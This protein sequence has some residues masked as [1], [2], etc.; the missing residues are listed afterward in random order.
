M[1]KRDPES[2]RNSDSLIIALHARSLGTVLAITG[3]GSGAVSALLQVSGA[4]R[5]VLEAVVPYSAVAL[6]DFLGAK[7]EHFC[8]ARTARMMA[9]VAF[10]RAIQ[11]GSR[12]EPARPAGQ[13][14]G[15]G[16]TASLASDR[17]K[18]GPHRAHIAVQTAA[19]T[20]TWSLELR[21]DARSRGDEEALV[22]DL[23]LNALAESA[24]LMERLELPLLDGEA[25]EADRTV[26]P[27][28]WRG[29]LLGERPIAP[30]RELADSPQATISP[31]GRAIFPGA[32]NPLHIGHQRM[33][34]VATQLLQLPVEYEISI[35]NVDKPPLDYTEMAARSKQFSSE[36]WLCFTRAATFIE[37][38]RLFAGATFIVGADTIV[39]LAAPRYYGGNEAACRAALEEIASHRCR[40]LVFGRQTA[41][42]FQTL[43]DVELPSVLAAI[44][45]GVSAEE[46]REDISST[47]LRRQGD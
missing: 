18:R 6:R 26:A 9:A 17:L 12:E 5:T 27:P 33:A 44:C 46:F 47:A 7:P 25:V 13:V 20:A 38:S 37:K 2:L 42:G 21:K 3:G 35:V 4:S 22:A 29:L 23:A 10:R 28:A 1:A 32:F 43:A 15:V 41:A 36:Q 31:A 11:L 8:S 34:E 19:A 40:F 30:A 39:R 14:A 45:R 16:C 24:G